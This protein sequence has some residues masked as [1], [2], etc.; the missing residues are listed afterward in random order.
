MIIYKKAN[1]T[2]KK[3][4]Q[5]SIKVQFNLKIVR[6]KQKANKTIINKIKKIIMI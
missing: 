1:N 4:R 3:S 6:I 2:K 5:N